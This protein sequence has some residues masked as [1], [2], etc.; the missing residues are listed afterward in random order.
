MESL[1]TKL[2]QIILKGILILPMDFNLAH[3]WLKKNHCTSFEVGK[4][5]RYLWLDRKGDLQIQ[6]DGII[7]VCHTTDI[8]K[9]GSNIYKLNFSIPNKGTIVSMSSET[10]GHS[11]WYIEC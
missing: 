11:C 5:Y 7:F 9:D 6:E 1:K 4:K 8:T 10:I 2:N 3:R